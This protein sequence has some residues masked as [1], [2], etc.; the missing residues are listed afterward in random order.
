MYA[1][2]AESHYYRFWF[3]KNHIHSQKV[4]LD[5]YKKNYRSTNQQNSK[6]IVQVKGKKYATGHIDLE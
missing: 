3:F 5:D 4:P 1:W 2:K 6:A